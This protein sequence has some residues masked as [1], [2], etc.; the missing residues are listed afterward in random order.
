[1]SWRRAIDTVEASLMHISLGNFHL[2]QLKHIKHGIESSSEALLICYKWHERNRLRLASLLLNSRF[3][4]NRVLPKIR[5]R[6]WSRKAFNQSEIKVFFLWIFGVESPLGGFEEK[7]CDEILRIEKCNKSNTE[8]IFQ[9]STQNSFDLMFYQPQDQLISVQPL[10]IPPQISH[11]L[12]SIQ[13]VQKFTR[14][15]LRQC[16]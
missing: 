6:F 2:A 1:M 14:I 5:Q 10:N 12:S 16:K 8:E 9:K 13:K 4:I 15:M 7:I 11:C 3:S